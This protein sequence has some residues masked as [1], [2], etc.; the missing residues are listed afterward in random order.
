MNPS[1][2]QGEAAGLGDLFVE[3]YEYLRCRI[4]DQGIDGRGELGLAVLVGRGVRAWMELCS[5][6]RVAPLLPR[7]A[8]SR[9]L[10]PDATRGELVEVLVGMALGRERLEMKS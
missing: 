6:A 10:L 1:A 4:L 9:D 7:N 8:T 5:T 2:P 3:N